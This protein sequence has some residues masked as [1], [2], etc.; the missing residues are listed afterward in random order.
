MNI[1]SHIDL[2]YVWYLNPK[3]RIF[4]SNPH[5]SISISSLKMSM[6]YKMKKIKKIIDLN[7]ITVSKIAT[8]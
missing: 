5:I 2:E 3:I 6:E 4:K 7:S 1:Q 8:F